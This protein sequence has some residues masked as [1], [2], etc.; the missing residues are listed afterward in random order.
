MSEK[1]EELNKFMP[2]DIKVIFHLHTQPVIGAYIQKQLNFQ[3]CF[4]GYISFTSKE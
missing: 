2:R 3:S 4:S 1:D